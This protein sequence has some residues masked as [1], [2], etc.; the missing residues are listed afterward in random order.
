M[1]ECNPSV[2]VTSRPARTAP[3]GKYGGDNGEEQLW[4]PGRIP[5]VSLC[6]VV[7]CGLALALIAQ[8]NTT[9]D[10]MWR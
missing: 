4:S 7:A 2:A 5:S 9:Q 6:S 8:G 10:F 3:E 1:P